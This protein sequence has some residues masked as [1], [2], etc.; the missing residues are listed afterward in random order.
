[1]PFGMAAFA[2]AYERALRDHVIENGVG[3]EGIAAGAPI[4]EVIQLG[5]PFLGLKTPAEE[6]TNGVF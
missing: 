1:M 4:N 3:E 2:D 6:M 5:G